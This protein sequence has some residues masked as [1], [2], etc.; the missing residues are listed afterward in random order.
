MHSAPPQIGRPL[1]QDT[2]NH[3]DPRLQGLVDS[4]LAAGV[5]LALA[6]AVYVLI[7]GAP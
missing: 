6:L 2:T 5:L 4:V 1:P 7:F 3:V